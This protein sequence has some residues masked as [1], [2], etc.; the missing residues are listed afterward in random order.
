M[1]ARKACIALL[2]TIC[3]PLFGQAA[4]ADIIQ[5]EYYS[6]DAQGAN[7]QSS[8]SKAVEFDKYSGSELL[9]AVI[10]DLSI[11]VYDGTATVD[12][13]SA[14]EVSV[15]V[16]LGASV[17]LQ[18]STVTLPTAWVVPNTALTNKASTTYNLSADNGDGAG[19][20]DGSGPDGAVFTPGYQSRLLNT[21]LSGGDI[22]SYRGGG[23]FSITTVVEDY[24]NFTAPAGVDT[25]YTSVYTTG[26]L[27]VTYVTAAGSS[28]P[29]PASM[30]LMASGLGGL[31][32][33]R[34]RRRRASRGSQ[35]A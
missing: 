21:S 7:M 25:A 31:A 15:T 26:Y 6:R 11:G 14:S 29:E 18:P 12:N 23:T 24:I 16:E 33:W 9:T 35:P 8:Y 2:V 5:T 20:P 3:L 32:Y 1:P 34:Y 17:T 4:R 22:W 10:I 30:L 27:K 19:S 13:D 28:A